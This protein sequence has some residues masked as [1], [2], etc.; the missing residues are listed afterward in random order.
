VIIQDDLC[1][2]CGECVDI[3]P[4]GAIHLQEDSGAAQISQQL[5][6]ECRVCIRW[7]GCPTNAFQEE[8]SLP[9]PRSV[10]RVFSDPVTTF[11][12]TTVSGRGTEEMKTNDV[13][14]RF[15][16]GSYGL[17][18][19]VGRPNVGAYLRDVDKITRVLAEAGADFSRNNPIFTLMTDPEKGC[20]SS[21]V[22]NERVLSAVVECTVTPDQ[23]PDAI[24]CLQDISREIDTVFS[25]GFIANVTEL[26]DR[27][28]LH[29]LLRECGIGAENSA[30]INVGLGR[31]EP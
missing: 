20:L 7:D 6:L 21:E 2:G 15:P 5:C 8:N 10:R 27:E 25:L 17:S 3:C 24:R 19:D 13:T 22:L 4:G 18:I 23:L 11:E 14:H 29:D 12:E 26:R 28:A 1:V 16:P 31:K 30:K 9:W